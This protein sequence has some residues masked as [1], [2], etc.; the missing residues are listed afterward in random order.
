MTQR[1]SVRG[2][3]A[4]WDDEAGWGVLTSPEVPGE[5]WAHF[6][7]IRLADPG[8]YRA[9]RPRDAVLFTWEEADQDGYS[10][11]AVEVRRASDVTGS[12]VRGQDESGDHA[13]Y[14]SELDLRW[15]SDR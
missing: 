9:L 11:R 10:F 3:V 2:Q 1:R 13:G 15:D 14:R 6:S 7:A 4:S 8:G 5:V 12:T